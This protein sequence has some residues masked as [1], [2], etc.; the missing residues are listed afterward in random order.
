VAT[1]TYTLAANVENLLMLGNLNGAVGNQLNNRIEGDVLANKI[2]GAD[3]ND[4]LVGGAGNDSLE[5]GNGNDVFVVDVATDQITDTA[6]TDWVESA[7]ISLDL[8]TAANWTGVENAR[9]TG[10]TA[11]NVTGNASNNHLVGNA[12]NNTLSGLGGNDTLA[13]GLGNDTYVIGTETGTIT[14]TEAAAGGT[15]LVQSS[16]TITLALNVENLTLT[17]TSAVNGT[18][19]I[20]NNL[21]NG[22]SAN[23]TL[24]GLAGNDTLNGAG[25]TADTLDG[26]AGN[27]TYIVDTG[28]DT[29]FEAA[30]GGT[31]LVQSSAT[32]TL[33]DNVENL[34]L[35]GTSAVNGTGNELINNVILG[36]SANNTLSG[37][38]GNDTLDGASGNDQ[39]AGGAGNDKLN[40][41]VGADTL[42]GGAGTDY[43]DLTETTLAQDVIRFAAGDSLATTALTAD[44]VM[45]FSAAMDKLDL[46]GTIEFGNAEA[47]NGT[48]SGSIKSHKITNGI[49]QFDDLD[50][51]TAALTAS[52]INTNLTSVVEYLKL[53]VT[54]NSTVA[55]QAGSDTW[56]FQDG[57]TDTLI[58]LIGVTGI[59]S[60]SSTDVTSATLHIV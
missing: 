53:N 32:I 35:T 31:A 28:T 1:A 20:G 41:G 54:G 23:N 30:S 27:D 56:V 58:K 34:T 22:N 38:G 37:L 57:T 7:T 10:T 42:D 52:S 55:F 15:D 4:T 48:D 36:N 2:Q 26:G 17:G 14:L 21:I 51:F 3:G 29:V 25:G 40:G 39:L 45:K 46:A 11:L 19:N 60:L 16:A 8:S 18:G 43:L 50:T 5:G 12:A 44:S 6:G 24:S 49:V 9:L 47:T 33:A 13:G 59:T